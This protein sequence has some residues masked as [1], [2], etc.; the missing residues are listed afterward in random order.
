MA[1]IR[2]LREDELGWAAGVY[3]EIQFSASPPG[4]LGLVAE[5]DGERVGLGRLVELEPGVLELGGIWCDDR[6][7]R[8]G[9]AR[10]MVTALVARAP[11]G[12]LWCIPF[13]HLAEFYA[14]FGFAEV[15]APWPD[16]IAAKV[17]DCAAHRYP[18]VVQARDS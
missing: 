3:Q 4:A 5:L 12:R 10:A 13:A 11:A 7:R 15:P 14:S 16:G 6:A 9:V 8:R 17:A 1:A 2:R 18:I